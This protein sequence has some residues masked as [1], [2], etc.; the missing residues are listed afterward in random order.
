MEKSHKLLSIKETAYELGISTPMLRVL[1]HRRD[2]Q[3]VRIGR[4]VL[5]RPADVAAF[6]EARVMPVKGE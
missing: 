5:V 2:I 3:H 1:I 4:R 6:V